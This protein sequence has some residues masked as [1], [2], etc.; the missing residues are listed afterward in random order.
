M[1]PKQE[2]LPFS[3]SKTW[4]R[5]GG[6][7]LDFDHRLSEINRIDSLMRRID[8]QIVNFNRLHPLRRK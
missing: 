2:P 5:K 1:T 6:L 7:G 4:G 3:G 8:S